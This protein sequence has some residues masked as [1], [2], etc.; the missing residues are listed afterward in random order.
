M[1]RPRL[2]FAQAAVVSLRRVFSNPVQQHPSGSHFDCGATGIDDA[3][4]TSGA[5]RIAIHAA[6]RSPIEDRRI[7]PANEVRANRF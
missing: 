5:K 3:P 7:R 2:T 6:T 4:S 1:G